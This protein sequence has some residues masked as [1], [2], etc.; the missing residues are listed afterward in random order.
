MLFSTSNFLLKSKQLHL[1]LALW[2][3]VLGKVENVRQKKKMLVSSISSCSHNVSKASYTE[4]YNVGI[5]KELRFKV[6]E[7]N[8]CGACIEEMFAFFF[9]QSISSYSGSRRGSND[10]TDTD[11]SSK[12]SRDPKDQVRELKVRYLNYPFFMKF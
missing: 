12:D 1:A 2:K 8:I 4:S 7:I 10:S 9:L 11:T 3:F 6:L 5:V